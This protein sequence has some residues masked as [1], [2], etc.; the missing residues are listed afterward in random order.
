MSKRKKLITE[1]GI[2]VEYLIDENGFQIYGD[3]TDSEYREIIPI[4]ASLE[5]EQRSS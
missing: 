2:E 3:Y 1:S 4:V 5:V